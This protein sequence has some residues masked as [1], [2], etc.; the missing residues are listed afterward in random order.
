MFS[1]GLKRC[2][3]YENKVRK[4]ESKSVRVDKIP[5]PEPKN[6][7]SYVY[8][9]LLTYLLAFTKFPLKVLI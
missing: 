2:F 8:F 3:G 9:T 5:Y 6:C 7:F 4:V 1:E